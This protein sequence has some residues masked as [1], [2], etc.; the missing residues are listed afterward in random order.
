MRPVEIGNADCKKVLI[1]L[2]AY[3]SSELTVETAIEVAR[4]LERCPECLHV[5]RIRELVKKR[6]QA[7]VANDE[8]S[9][10][11]KKQI[12]RMIRKADNFRISCLFE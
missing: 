12:S 9:P 7:A 3:L 11:M 5:Y 8:V 4:H 6:L 1:L 10:E 2:D